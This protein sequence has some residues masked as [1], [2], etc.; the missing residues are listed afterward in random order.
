[1]EKDIISK[2]SYSVDLAKCMAV[3]LF[4]NNHM[5]DIYPIRILACGGALGNAL[6]FVVSGYTWA[7]INERTRLFG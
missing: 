4:L 3:L 5:K 2:R 6:F 7:G 1:M